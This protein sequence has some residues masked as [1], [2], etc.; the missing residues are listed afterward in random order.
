MINSVITSTG[1]MELR[2]SGPVQADRLD[3]TTPATLLCFSCHALYDKARLANSPV[4]FGF[5]FS[6]LAKVFFFVIVC[7]IVVYVHFASW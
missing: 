5:V 2:D 7:C 4:C 6:A 3:S 1:I